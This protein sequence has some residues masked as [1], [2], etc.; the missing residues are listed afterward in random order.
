MRDQGLAVLLISHNLNHVFEKCD[1]I[2]VLK[3]GRLVG[4]RRVAETTQD[5]IVRMIVSGGARE[6]PAAEPARTATA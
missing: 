6:E 3:T 2:T 1:R 4:S 5:E